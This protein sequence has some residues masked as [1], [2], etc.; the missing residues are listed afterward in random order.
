MDGSSGRM[1]SEMEGASERLAAAVEDLRATMSAGAAATSGAF[2]DG[3]EAIL[4]ADADDARR[5][6]GEHRRRRSSDGPTPLRRCVALPS[7]SARNCRR[8]RRKGQW[9]PG[10]GW[11]EAAAMSR[12]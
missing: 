9:R 11:I 10:S 4:A 12:T 5:D 2:S 3:V 6:Q 1:G 8:R 7:G